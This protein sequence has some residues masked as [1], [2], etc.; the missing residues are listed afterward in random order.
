MFCFKTSIHKDG[1]RFI[2]PLL[3]LTTT[4]IYYSWMY[5]SVFST[6]FTTW[7]IFFFRNPA[8]NLPVNENIFVS[9]ATGKVVSIENVIPPKT[10]NLSDEKCTKISIFLNIF[11][12]HVNRSPLDAK[13]LDIIYHK[14]QFFNASLD[15]ASDKNERNAIIMEHRTMKIA[16][17][18][19]AGLIA[20]RIVCNVKP[21]Q[22]LNRGDELGLIRFG[23]RV[24]IY[25]DK[26]IKPFV[27]VGQ[28]VHVGE[29]AIYHLKDNYDL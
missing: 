26:I 7:V 12:I 15:K 16:I 9:P 3:I 5:L 4:S 13:I 18:Q 22:T 1:W 25:F 29:T 23:S 24:D 8:P 21:N 10:Y 2:I 14:G 28:K 11:D 17:V 27:Q 20:R 19:I 6:F